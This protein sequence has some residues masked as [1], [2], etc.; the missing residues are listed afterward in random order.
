MHI[1]GINAY[2]G[3]ASAC[4]IRDGVL[5]AAAEEERFNRTKYWAGF[6]A[7]AIR[8][9]LAE[10]GIDARQLD[11]VAISR[12]PRANLLRKILW[13]MRRRPRIGYVTDRL[14]NQQNVAR[15]DDTFHEALGLRERSAAHF[16]R[17]EHHRAHM[18]SAFFVSPFERA[19][20]L[21]V[22]GMG[23]F[24]STMWGSGS[25]NRL[26][27]Q[28]AIHFP[29]SLGL[30]YTLVTQW[31][32]F[33]AYGDE[34]KT[35]GLA[36]YGRPVHAEALREVV[37]VQSDGTFELDLD[38]FVHDKEGT[39]LSWREGTPTSSALYSR[40]FIDRFGQPRQKG[41]PLTSQHEDMAA[42]LQFVLEEALEALLH[43]LHAATGEENLVLAGGVA[44]NGVF[45]GQ[46]RQ[47]TPFRNIFIQPAAGD[48]GTALGAAYFVYHQLLG[49]PRTFVMQHAYTGTH[50]ADAQIAG[51]LRS[52]GCAFQEL[53]PERIAQRAADLI[54]QGKVL[55]WF[56][57]RME[58]GPRALGHRS[59]VADPRRPDMKD[60]L[61]ARIKQREPFR[62]F[63][64]SILESDTAQYFDQSAPDPFMVVV[65]NVLPDKRAVI[66]AVTH[67]DG[68]GRL[69][70]VNAAH[71]PEFHALI[72]AFKER[73]GVP[74]VLNTSFNENEPIVSAP[75][76]AIDCFARTR[77]DALAIG[78]FLVE[79]P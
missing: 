47:R 31:L 61:N 11:H 6:P 35:M 5:L 12:D 68:S 32:G 26:H 29:H 62:P 75:A 66:P 13:G 39:E 74:V 76:E 40:K 38:Y 48:A 28:N 27:V 20:V 77:M 1:L 30:F 67:V 15:F 56:Q 60:I 43:K 23:D 44:L 17:V 54:V 41:Q 37:R 71:A 69:Q 53:D 70:T 19:A 9:C 16:H 21:S 2:H 55:G 50:F 4:L 42:S 33:P 63:A 78:S 34:G 57:G 58:W 51:A 64:P 73:T 8:W 72:S 22:D 18:A 14:I 52:A 7:Q 3:G 65:Y 79:K 46:I 24:V 25:G 36:S 45:N 59:I 10:A 49:K